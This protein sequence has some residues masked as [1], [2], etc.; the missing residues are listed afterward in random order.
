[1]KIDSVRIENFRSFRDQT[2]FFD[3]YTCLVG[4]NGSGKST[5]LCALNVFFR[6]G[7]NSST[8]VINLSHED[9]HQ[10]K[11][12]KPITITVTFG[13]LTAEAQED[14]K[15]YYRQGKLI[16]SAVAEYNA[17]TGRAD[18]QQFGLRTGMDQFRPFFEAL[19]NG[20]PVTGLRAIFSGL[21]GSFPGI[22]ASTAKD[23]MIAAL[24]EFESDPSNAHLCTEIPSAD[25]FYGFSKGSNR[26]AKHVQWVFIPAVKDVTAE[27]SEGKS[28]ALGKI[29]ARTVRVRLRFD[30]VIL[31]LQQKTEDEYRKILDSNQEALSELEKSLTERMALWAHPAA[32]IHLTWQRDSKRAVQ[33]EPPAARTLAGEGGFQGDLARLGH[34]FQRSYLLALLQI[35]ATSGDDADAPKLILACEEPELYQHPPQARHLATVLEQLSEQEA[36]VMVCTHNPSM[37]TGKG[38]ESVR[39]IRFDSVENCSGCHQLKFSELAARLGALTGKPPTKPTGLAAKLHQE[40]QPS[41]NELF[42]TRNLVLVEG[43]EDVAIITSWLVLTGRWSEFRQKG[44]HIVPAGGKSHLS[45]ALVIAQGLKIPVFTIFDADGDDDKH[46]ALHQRDNTLLHKLLDADHSKPFPADILWN[47]KFAVWPTNIGDA[48]KADVSE[49]KMR[50]YDDKANAA[51]GSPGGLKKN[52][53]QIGVK[54]QLAFEGGSR[55]ASLDKLCDAILAFAK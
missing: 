22:A 17:A 38:F 43:L 42:F 52:S 36:Q 2:I 7:E 24:R 44:I 39:L 32:S 20:A 15:D 9:F 29:L 40:L 45:Y 25:S 47:E 31:E 11:T 12:D 4:A 54:L 53:L 8:D 19:K 41:I 26:L 21:R 13:D 55:P 1:M 5:V 6:D 10:K 48:I 50:T 37:V 51:H 18:V 16:I 23:A 34:G 49:E 35:L 14:F 30:E 46:K 33:I 28:T 27:Q 3:D